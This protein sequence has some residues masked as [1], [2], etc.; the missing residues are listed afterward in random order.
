MKAVFLILA[1][2]IGVTALIAGVMMVT[3]CGAGSLLAPMTD[4][5]CGATAQPSEVFAGFVA[6]AAVPVLALTL[7]VRWI[8]GRR[9]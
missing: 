1:A 2:A 8:R 6:L 9:S 3:I 5:Q 7:V 4:G